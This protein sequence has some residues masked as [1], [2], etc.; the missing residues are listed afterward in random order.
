MI[1]CSERVLAS[2]SFKGRAVLRPSALVHCRPPHSAQASGRAIGCMFWLMSF[3]ASR[4][5]SPASTTTLVVPSPTS[6]SCTFEMSTSTFAAGLSMYRLCRMVAPSLVTVTLSPLCARGTS[7]APR[8]CRGTARHGL[9]D[10]VHA[11][12]PQ[13]ALHQV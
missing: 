7:A 6:A 10:L 4:S 11:L 5:S 12:R 1:V 9:Q 13:R 3:S 8:A 2:A